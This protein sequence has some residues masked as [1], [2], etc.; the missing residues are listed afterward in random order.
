LERGGEQ[1]SLGAVRMS[2]PS[3]DDLPSL[4]E[5]S[6]MPTAAGV[7]VRELYQTRHTRIVSGVCSVAGTVV[8]VN[9]RDSRLGQPDGEFNRCVKLEAKG[10]EF[11]SFRRLW[12]AV[13]EAHGHIGKTC[14]CDVLIHIGYTFGGVPVMANSFRKWSS[15][16]GKKGVGSLWADYKEAVKERP[17]FAMYPMIEFSFF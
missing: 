6:P 8:Y 7:E 5:V 10:Q 11:S 2:N 12:D 17:P 3:G 9:V 14:H 1:S 4:R 16:I 13:V 15:S